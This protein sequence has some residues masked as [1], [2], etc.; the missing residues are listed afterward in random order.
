[1]TRAALLTVATT[2]GFAFSGGLALATGRRVRPI[3]HRLSRRLRLWSA[4]AVAS[5][6]GA[7]V[8]PGQTIGVRLCAALMGSGLVILAT[9]SRE[10]WLA[11]SLLL[12]AAASSRGGALVTAISAGVLL[13]VWL[14]RQRSLT[15]LAIGGGLVANGVLRLDRGSAWVQFMVGIAA[16]AVVVVGGT[17]GGQPGWRVAR[18]VGAGSA[19]VIAVFVGLGA[20]A[21]MQARSHLQTGLR[22]AQGGL[23][24]AERGQGA[25]ATVGLRTASAEF[26]SGEMRL[27]AWWAEPAMR[28][29]VLGPN[30]RA[31]ETMARVGRDLT[32]AAARAAAVANPDS[33]HVVGG[34]VPLDRLTAL[35]RPLK[36]AENALVQA[37]HNLSGLGSPWL[38]GSV[39]SRLSDLRAKV[40]KAS[41]DTATA[42]L[43]AR[44]GPAMLGAQGTRRYFL[45]I[46]TPAEARG[47]GGMIGAY[48]EI[49]ASQGRVQLG[50]LGRTG[51]LS[52]AAASGRARVDGPPDFL[53]RYGPDLTRGLWQ[54]IAESPDFPTVAKV[55]EDLYPKSGG[56]H[57]DGV[58][59]IDPV[60]LAAVLRLVGPVQVAAWPEP[61]TADNVAQ[62][63][64][65]DEYLRL[66][67]SARI[68]FLGTVAGAVVQRLTTGDLSNLQQIG[69]VLSGAVRSKHIMMDVPDTHEH[70]F[71][72]RFGITGAIGSVRDDSVAV[73]TENAG[74]NKIDWYLR[75]SVH[76]D[77]HLTPATKRFEA[78]MEIT[79]R[80][81]APSSG[82]ALD[83]LGNVV[84]A[85]LPLGT[86]R[87]VLS[88]YTPSAL[89]W[90]NRDGKRLPL[91]SQFELGR[92]V[93]S[94]LV[95]IPPMG[96][97]T[98][99]LHLIGHYDGR[100]YAARVWEQPSVMPQEWQLTTSSSG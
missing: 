78:T 1:M 18:Y 44:L 32:A 9:R 97:T 64:L 66:S 100:H 29:P 14:G 24:A 30:L 58:I 51:D 54:N 72:T 22:L 31:L 52:E 74:G 65:H 55:I 25:G 80:N 21:A 23:T 62:V 11:I 49:V 82:E 12:V 75:R 6:V 28:L 53:A 63:L 43:G 36:D 56:T 34:S 87:L 20:L 77:V 57:V 69:H 84:D 38:V 89:D 46:L 91:Q 94:T 76:Y 96:Q 4:V 16:V 99:M 10:V 98:V 83:V 13:A 50:K 41:G 19:G 93:Y 45:A 73:I 5:G 37:S 17:R 86:N 67:G 61:L 26:A 92:R 15:L 88:V 48:G 47:I 33:I 8:V 35:D 85:T 2:A 3:T 71:L 95:D 70:D 40:D 39:R 68:D 60:G 81:L 7:A 79:L 90:A 59:A 42:A 27:A